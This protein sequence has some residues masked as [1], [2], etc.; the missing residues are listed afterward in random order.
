LAEH[1][2][3][4]RFL[5]AL[6]LRH[7]VTLD[8]RDEALLNELLAADVLW[9]GAAVTG[10]DEARGAAQVIA[11]WKA[12]ARPDGARIEVH[13]VFADGLHTIAK[14]EWSVAGTQA[15]SQ[16]QVFH[17]N[18]DGKVTELW[19]L[20]TDSEVA[21]ALAR[22]E[23]VPDHRNLPVF[24]TAEETR[25]RNTFEPDDLAK[26]NAFLREDVRWLGA[27]ED[28]RSEAA[29]G[30]DQVIGLFQTFKQ[31]TGGTIHMDLHGVFADDT[32]A[33][34]FVAITADRPDKPGR[35]MD[36]KEVNLFHLDA[37]GRAFEFWGVPNDPAIMDA[38]WAP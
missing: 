33:L 30:R 38:F 17:L 27:N 31:A 8:A 25:A 13:D 6:E 24:R 7:G 14:L 26:I 10:S 1:P 36:L 19:S 4:Q 2:D 23:A 37:D 16:A 28:R 5:Q 3:V 12:P 29:G 21:E 32:H 22:N 35:H 18:D 9:H 34:S 15:V 20:P 11:L